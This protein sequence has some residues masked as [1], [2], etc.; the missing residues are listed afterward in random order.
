M[1]VANRRL[2]SESKDTD[3]SAKPKNTLHIF[4]TQPSGYVEIISDLPCQTIV[5]KGTRIVYPS[6]PSG[7]TYAFPFVRFNFIGPQQSNT[8]LDF[9]GIP[10]LANIDYQDTTANVE[11]T[12]TIGKNSSKKFPYSVVDQNGT[13]FPPGTF[14]AIQLIFEY[15]IDNI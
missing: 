15:E 8:N 3:F 9:T 1:P 12:F 13:L 11:M 10:I 4:L 6:T 2:I 14:S 5:L 7:L